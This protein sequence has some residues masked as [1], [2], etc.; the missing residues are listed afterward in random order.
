MYLF[1]DVKSHIYIY[2][3][4]GIYINTAVHSYIY[5]VTIY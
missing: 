1:T 4:N 2:I 5:L 3:V